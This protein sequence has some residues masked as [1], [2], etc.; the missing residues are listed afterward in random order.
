MIANIDKTN[1]LTKCIVYFN[2]GNVHTF[3]SLDKKHKNSKQDKAL[4]MRRLDKMLTGTFKAKFETAII[5]D[6][7]LNG[8][9][10]AK[11]K[12][13]VRVN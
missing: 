11:Y 1:S 5:Y 13:G 7:E 10:L 12:R 4:G 2:D 9:E 3:Y 8:A 6:N